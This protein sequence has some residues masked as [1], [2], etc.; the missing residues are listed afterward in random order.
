MSSVSASAAASAAAYAATISSGP[1]SDWIAD[2]MT[3]I[4]N[5]ATSGGI[6]GA[7]A[8]SGNGSI[9]SVIKQTSLMATNFA[10]ISQNTV[11]NASAFYAQLASQA[12]Q[13]RAQDALKKALEALTASR[14]QVKAENVLDPYI[15]L[16]GGTTID[17]ANGIM[18]R[19]DGTQYDIAT[20]A[21]YV[22]VANVIQMANGS[23]L[24]TKNNILTLADGTKID[25]VTGLKVSVTA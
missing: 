9:K 6:L 22:D 10:L 20:G 18:T 14:N 15:Y 17:T 8:G 21:L 16:A 1:T 12:Q 5:S 2:T 13:Q 24:D 23:Y 7:L 3:A 11:T 19:P 25:T 4:K